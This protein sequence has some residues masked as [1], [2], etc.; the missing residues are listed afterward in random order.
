MASKKTATRSTTGKVKG[1]KA[2][3][4][5]WREKLQQSRIKFDDAMK[6]RYL[7]ALRQ[8]NGLKTPAAAAVGVSLQTVNNHL[9]NDPDFQ[10]AHAA[11]HDEWKDTFVAHH[12]NLALNGNVVRK[13]NKDGDLIEE[14]TE[15]PIRLIEL[16]LKKVEPGYR[17]KQQLDINHS[18]GGVLVAPADMSPEDWI[19]QQEEAN[20]SKE[21]P[22][23]DVGEG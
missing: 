6:E 22:S 13:Y 1:V 14:K 2:N 15:Y 9:E 10:E 17:D 23:T 7:E 5:N 20:A 18:G 16:E 12:Q 11:V 19:K 3:Q 4:T 8:H 21:K